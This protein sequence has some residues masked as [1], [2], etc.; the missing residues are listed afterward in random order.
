NFVVPKVDLKTSTIYEKLDGIHVDLY[1][2]DNQWHIFEKEQFKP[3]F[4][5]VHTSNVIQYTFKRT[6][7]IRF[8]IEKKFWEIWNKKRYKLPSDN[9]ICFNFE[10]LVKG[11]H[12]VVIHE[13]DDLILYAARRMDT[14]QEL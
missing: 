5:R 1:W 13:T 9:N 2:Y 4:K 14:L 8:D 10:M 3:Q 7:S 6:N 12:K 11:H